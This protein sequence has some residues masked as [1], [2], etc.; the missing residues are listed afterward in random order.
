[1]RTN[2]TKIHITVISSKATITLEIKLKEKQL[3]NCAIKLC[4]KWC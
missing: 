4:H 2:K 3:Q 1:M